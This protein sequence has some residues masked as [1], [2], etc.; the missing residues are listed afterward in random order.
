MKTHFLQH[1]TDGLI[2]QPTS[3]YV[4]GT[5]DTLLKWKPAEMNSVDF[6]VDEEWKRAQEDYNTRWNPRYYLM[7]PNDKG[8][9]SCISGSISRPRS[10]RAS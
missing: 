6:C 4:H 2:F 3:R 9:L 1:G 10:R 7:T 8:I 5:D